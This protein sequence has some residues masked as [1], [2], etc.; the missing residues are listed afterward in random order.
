MNIKKK[1]FVCGTGWSGSDA[2]YYYFRE[3][4]NV[5][6][7]RPELKIIVRDPEHSVYAKY[8]DNSYKNKEKYQ[9][10]S[11]RVLSMIAKQHGHNNEEYL[12][13]SNVVPCTRIFASDI[14]L[15][16]TFFCV[17]R[18][19][20]SN[21]V[22]CVQ[23]DSKVYERFGRERTLERYIK[24]YKKAMERFEEA[25][26]KVK[27]SGNTI[28]RVRFEDFILSDAYKKQ[29]LDILGLDL[30]NYSKTP[31]VKPWPPEKN[32]YL[33]RTYEKQNEIKTIEKELTKYC[34]EF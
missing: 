7:V 33:H 10:L 8:R 22:A 9:Q 30:K 13:F 21:W 27:N 32:I 17:F 24:M 19:P 20:R 4:S 34:Y 14:L 18:D 28:I 29:L 1:I 16:S 2:L 26:Q 6:G 11:E 12:L 25:Y 3:F 23:E 31:E 5:F 15:D